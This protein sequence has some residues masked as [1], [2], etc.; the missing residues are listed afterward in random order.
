MEVQQRVFKALLETATQEGG[1]ALP[2]AVPAKAHLR[3]HDAQFR[4]EHPLVG[5][6][7]GTSRRYDDPYDLWRVDSRCR[8]ERR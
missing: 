4:R 2:T 8:S 3:E 1:G 7:D 5:K 6:I